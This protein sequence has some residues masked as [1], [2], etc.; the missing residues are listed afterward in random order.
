VA[1]FS[2][3]PRTGALLGIDLQ[4]CFV[5]RS[6]VA[7]VDGLRVVKR[8]NQVASSVRSSGGV[9]IWTRY[10]VRPDHANAG[11]LARTV[12]PVQTGLIDDRAT[13]AALRPLVDVG[14]DVVVS[15]SQFG[16]FRET[17][18]GH[19]SSI[20]RYCDDHYRWNCDERLL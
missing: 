17:D 2:V 14:S 4:S 19:H 18:P 16:A 7:A 11:M 13:T 3:D 20:K 12:P 8:L 10:V 15:K 5:E 1:E 6:C 9:V